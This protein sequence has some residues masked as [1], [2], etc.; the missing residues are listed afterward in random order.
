M[1]SGAVKLRHDV[2]KKSSHMRRSSDNCKSLG[3]YKMSWKILQSEHFTISFSSH[4]ERKKLIL[5][6]V[7]YV[8]YG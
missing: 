2:G 3:R 5:E 8:L 4:S 1:V 7:D 6:S